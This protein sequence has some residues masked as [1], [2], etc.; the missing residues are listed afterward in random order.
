YPGGADHAER[1]QV[2]IA[3]V[4]DSDNFSGFR[5]RT[6]EIRIADVRGFGT[7]V[8]G[9]EGRGAPDRWLAPLHVGATLHG[10]RGAGRGATRGFFFRFRGGWR[11]RSIG[12][13]ITRAVPRSLARRRL[14]NARLGLGLAAEQR[15]ADHADVVRP[16][17]AL[18]VGI[19]VL[20]EEERRDTLE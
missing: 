12:A 14:V 15:D 4:T 19:L 17:G 10:S 18:S 3:V 9:A 5:R 16:P 7:A 6:L 8:A 20:G 13:V 2:A 1:D 11:G